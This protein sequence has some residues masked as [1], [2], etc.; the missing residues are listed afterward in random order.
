MNSIFKIEK[1]S[2]L[3]EQV[4]D[5]IREAIKSGKLKPGDRLIET[6]LANGMQISR[7]AI[8]EAIRYL[9]KEGLVTTTPFKGAHV[10]EFT[11]KDLEDLYTLRTAL[12]ELAIRT[13]IK[14]LDNEKI[15]KLEAV[16]KKMEHVAKNGTIKEYIDADLRFHQE[17][18]KLSNNQK[19]LEM[20][21][22]LEHQMRAF[23]GLEEQLYDVDTPI[24]SMKTHI[25]V[26][27]AIKK[28]DS[29]LAAKKMKEVITR[30]YTLA[31]RHYK[32]KREE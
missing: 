29:N 22:T 4:A 13:L 17:I 16:L 10:T 23:I 30:G 8:R 15:N 31:S 19:L 1:R 25:P 14:N 32:E 24:K 12:E 11:E 3:M 6:E 7:S 26:F 18:C 9:E 27:Q 5:Q 28:S 21:S 2:I 20:W